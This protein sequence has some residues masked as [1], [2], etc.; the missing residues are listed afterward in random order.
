M[1]EEQNKKELER[2]INHICSTGTPMKF[3]TYSIN[4]RVRKEDSVKVIGESR[5]TAVSI[6]G[7][8]FESLVTPYNEKIFND[9]K[10]TELVTV[11]CFTLN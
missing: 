8:S 6:D 5:V 3:P 11:Y 7:C 1:T 10:V 9:E 4:Q 2:S